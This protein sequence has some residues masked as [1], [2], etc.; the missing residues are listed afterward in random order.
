MPATCF[1]GLPRSAGV[2]AQRCLVSLQGLSEAWFA[3]R[4]LLA[5][6]SELCAAEGCKCMH[7]RAARRLAPVFAL[8][9]RARASLLVSYTTL[10]CVLQP[11][12][13]RSM[14]GEGKPRARK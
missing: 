5:V 13:Q 11:P 6:R 9:R 12:Q 4:A 14:Q 7:R 3:L 1:T 8:L 2:I 10:A